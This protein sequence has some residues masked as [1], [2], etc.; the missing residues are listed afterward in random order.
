MTDHGLSVAGC[1]H[2]CVDSWLHGQ[3][4]QTSDRHTFPSVSQKA[5][6]EESRRRQRPAKDSRGPLSHCRPP[7][8]GALRKTM[9]NVDSQRIKQTKKC[10]VML[11]NQR[12]STL[13]FEAV[14][15]RSQYDRSP[16]R[17]RALTKALASENEGRKRGNFMK[18]H[19]N[20]RKVARK[21]CEN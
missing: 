1:R 5:G 8:S 14:S 16:C 19:E 4:K 7:W 18:T 17:R 6:N 15:G 2:Q 12:F 21:Y 11:A 10:R 13:H 20:S 9:S 3:N